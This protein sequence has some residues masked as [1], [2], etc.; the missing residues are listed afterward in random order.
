VIVL[1]PNGSDAGVS[2]SEDTGTVSFTV[3]G[4]RDAKRA[5][6]MAGPVDQ[7]LVYGATSVGRC[8]YGTPAELPNIN[9]CKTYER[10]A[11]DAHPGCSRMCT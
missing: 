7:V 11:R 1:V 8:Q 9:N 10:D 2:E 6:T 5:H 4:S 3:D